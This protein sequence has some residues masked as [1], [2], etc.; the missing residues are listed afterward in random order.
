MVVAD[1]ILKIM[2]QKILINIK[3]KN[4]SIRVFKSLKSK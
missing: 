1:R 2:I 3:M 4:F